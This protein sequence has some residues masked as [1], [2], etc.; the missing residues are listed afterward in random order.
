MSEYNGV[1]L[2]GRSEIRRRIL[3]L[4]LDDPGERLHLREIARRALTSAGTAARELRLLEEAGLV[5]RD[6]EG[7]QVYFRSRTDSSLYP[8]VRALVHAM[9]REATATLARSPAPDSLGLQTARRLRLELRAVLGERLV[10][11]YLY[12]SRARGDH[13]ADSDIDVLVVLDEI[14]VYAADLRATG[15]ATSRLSLEA[16]VTISRL[17]A[18]RQSWL[19]RDRPILRVIA[20]E[21]IRV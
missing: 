19:R 7:R 16:G 13:D 15:E 8:P 17:L 14:G 21:G 9:G 2:L 20:A 18:T 11:V 5:A 3:G 4:L 12:G 10:G 6:R 1:S